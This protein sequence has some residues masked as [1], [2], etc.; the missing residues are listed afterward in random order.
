M[1]F[2]LLFCQS[3]LQQTLRTSNIT[4]II[5]EQKQIMLYIPTTKQVEVVL[6]YHALKNIPQISPTLPPHPFGSRNVIF[7]ANPATLSTLIMTVILHPPGLLGYPWTF[8]VH[9]IKK[10]HKIKS[11]CTNFCRGFFYEIFWFY[12][13]PPPRGQLHLPAPFTCHKTL[14]GDLAWD[15]LFGV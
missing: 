7:E 1:L 9:Q 8:G 5:Q 2:Y 6:W 3:L 12:A 13:P 4:I 10:L 15:P 14:G 11:Y